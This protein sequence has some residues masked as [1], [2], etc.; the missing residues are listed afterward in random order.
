[1]KKATLLSMLLISVNLVFAQYLGWE[2]YVNPDLITDYVETNNEIWFSSRG[3][4]IQL[5]KATL[6]T[7]T[8]DRGTSNIETNIVLAI[9]QDSNDTIWIAT[10]NQAIAKFDGTSWISFDF[11]YLFNTSVN[12][13]ETYCIEIDHQD[14]IWVGTN[15][16]LLRFDGANWTFFNS[17][18][19]AS[20]L[21]DVWAL[22]LDNQGNLY[23]SSFRVYKYDGV[24]FQSLSD[25]A[26]IPVYGEAILYWDSNDN[27]WVTN[28]MG[29]IGKFDGSNWTVYSN[30]SSQFP[31]N[32]MYTLGE[33]PNGEMY[34]TTKDSG[35]YVLQN[36]L[37]QQDDI[38]TY[39]PLDEG[40]LTT[41][42]YDNQGNEWL[43]N[44]GDL[45]K[46]DGQN[47][48]PIQLKAYKLQSNNIFD[49]EIYDNVK[50]FVT[51]NGITTYDGTTWGIFDYPDSL[52]GDWN[53]LRQIQIVNENNIWIASA[54]R[55]VLHWNGSV[56]TLYNQNN[57]PLLSGYLAE[58]LYDSTSQTLWCTSYSGLVKF[59]GTNWTQ[60]NMTNTPMSSDFI[61]AIAIDNNGLLH[62]SVSNTTLAEVWTY[63]G[64]TWQN[65]ATGSTAPQFAISKIYFDDNNTLWAGSWYG[66]V[67]KYD[68]TTWENWNIANSGLLGDN[69]VEITSDDLGNIY[70]ASSVGAAS[71]D[72]TIWTPWTTQNSGISYRI[73]NDLEI[74]N[75]GKLWFGTAHGISA[76]K[77][78]STSMQQNFVQKEVSKMKVYPNPI[79][80]K[81]MIEFEIN[82]STDNIQI[83]IISVDGRTISNRLIKESFSKGKQRIE[84]N[85]GSLVSG[86]YYLK[87][88]YNNQTII[89]PIFVR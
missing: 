87:L 14:N 24:S 23:A 5:N 28:T 11:S 45:V 30:V 64:T 49:V 42:F 38:A 21:H 32:G 47:V 74:D 79:I 31:S 84:I 3:G 63:D 55:G 88:N 50:Y 27:L 10:D 70:V 22:D 46:N 41:F 15:R 61:R 36:G 9:A 71:F 2:N 66:G 52:F 68:G 44:G 75:D 58:M 7:N 48:T 13:V 56:W 57:A 29:M 25:T 40:N 60:Y 69:T 8:Y 20:S 72:G 18:N 17:Q 59:D 4:V 34:F 86:L 43:A 80:D 82:S 62:V 78:I 26:G 67:Y 19:G 16:G 39:I 77:F 51:E 65:I 89:E 85:R 33:S 6:Q 76:Y 53:F 12:S 73:V 83:Q 54:N 35:K 81:A 1:M 37:W